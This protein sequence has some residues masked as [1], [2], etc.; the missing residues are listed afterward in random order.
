MSI[1]RNL[2]K[3][4]RPSVLTNR[5]IQ[6][7]IPTSNSPSSY[8]NSNNNNNNS[9][10]P[11]HSNTTQHHEALINFI[12]DNWNKV[13]TIF[14]QLNT[15]LWPGQIIGFYMYSLIVHIWLL[16]VFGILPALLCD[17]DNSLSIQKW[18]GL[19]RSLKRF[20]LNICMKAKKNHWIHVKRSYLT[21]HE[22]QKNDLMFL[23]CMETEAFFNN[24]FKSRQISAVNCIDFHI[25]TIEMS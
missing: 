10:T 1:D 18:T 9:N 19:K 11:A 20:I 22:L 6:R 8:N 17:F 5:D 15:F 23:I 12:H 24:Y 7:E 14:F 13:S 21:K 16:W 3:Q 2:S 25:C 4:H